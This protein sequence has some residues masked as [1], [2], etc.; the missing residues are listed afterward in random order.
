[1]VEAAGPL[2]TSRW[3]KRAAGDIVPKG[4]TRR[5][6]R[7]YFPLAIAWRLASYVATSDALPR[8]LAP[9]M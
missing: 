9:A 8:F 2:P 7:G 4:L 5:R 3:T 6:R 1:M